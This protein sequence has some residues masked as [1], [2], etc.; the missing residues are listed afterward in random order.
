MEEFLNIAPASTIRCF[1]FNAFKSA[2][3]FNSLLQPEPD[4]PALVLNQIFCSYLISGQGHVALQ[5]IVFWFQ[6]FSV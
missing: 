6:L 1:I 3:H 4:D 2:K 5:G